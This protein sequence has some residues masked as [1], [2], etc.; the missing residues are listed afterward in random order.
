MKLFRLALRNIKKSIKDYSIYFITLVIAV[1]IFYIF[2]SVDSQT[3]MMSINKSTMEIVQAIVNVLSYISVFVSI[4]LGFLIVYANN[5]L[6]KRRKKE[7]GIYLT[8]GMSKIK[9][10]TILV[11]ETIIVGVISLGIGL[12]LG[13]GLSQLLSI[14]TAKLFEADMTKF[15]FVFSSEALLSAVINFG[16]IYIIVMIFNIITLNRFKLIDLLYAN[17]KNEK[18]KIK[19]G[20]LIFTTFIVS[21]ILIGYAYKLLYDG[22]LLIVGSDFLIMIILGA[23]GTFLFFLSVSGFLL[24]VVQMRKK[25]YYKGLN[26]FILKQVNNKINTHVVSTTVISLMLLMTIGILSSSL[27]MASAMNASY[28]DNSP[29]DITVLSFDSEALEKLKQEPSYQEIVKKDYQFSYQNLKGLNQGDFISPKSDMYKE[30]ETLKKEPMR[31]V[32]ESDYNQIMSL[33]GKIDKKIQLANNQYQLVATLPMA[34]EYYNQFLEGDSTIKVGDISLTSLTE[35][36]VELSVTND[37]GNEGFIVVNDE[38]A[39][40]YGQTSERHEIYL[41]ADYQGDKE[42]CEE[43]FQDFISIFNRQIEDEGYHVVSFTRIELGQSGIGTSALFTFVGLYLGIVF[44]LASGT[45]LAIEQLSESSD[46]KERYRILGQLGASKPMVNRSLLVQIGITFMFPLVVALVHS[47]VALNEINYIISLMVSINIADNI[48]ITTIFIIV[49]YGGYY[50]ATYLA[51][52]RII[53]ER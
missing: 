30:M 25:T 2:N 51:S 45:V 24:K 29:S 1:A 41:V 13:V 7:I 46:N 50:L 44:A 27:A 33:N 22:A 16:F 19:N 32:K 10:S 52:N 23:F 36:V 31:V 4:V 40:K 42:V 20:W 18:V 9:V 3:A 48:L 6:I 17:R 28:L 14:F 12:I 37:S 35:Q 26:M 15:T 47:F 49:V 43:K 34:L 53:N 11:L 39:N 21:I 8:L 38:V 5:F